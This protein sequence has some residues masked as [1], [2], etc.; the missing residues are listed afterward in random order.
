ML[1]CN[2]SSDKVYL[3]DVQGEI[4]LERNGIEKVLW[5]TL[6]DRAK[7]SPFDHV[8]LLNGPG[9]FTNLRVGTLTWNLVAHLLHLEQK[10][11]K[12]FSCTKIDLYSYFVKKWVLPSVW[13]IYLWQ[14]NSVWKYDFENDSYKIVNQP[15]VFGKESFCDTLY[16]SSYWWENFDMV[17]FGSDDNW[18]FLMWKWE[19]C[20]FT[21]KDLDLKA[22]SAVSAEYMIDPTLG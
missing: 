4:F 15:F 13:Y 9:G 16:D 7:K 3:S 18:C 8:F 1:F 10:N 2:I 6:I 21:A 5:P 20:F 22:V 19:K 17:N 14:K 12:F 11:I